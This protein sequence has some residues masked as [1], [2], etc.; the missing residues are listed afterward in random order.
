M[1]AD[2]KLEILPGENASCIT[3][4][5]LNEDHTLGNALRY[6]LMKNP[7]VEFAG[8]SVPHPNEPKMNLR[9]QTRPGT[10]AIQILRKALLDLANVANA[11]MSEFTAKSV[12]LQT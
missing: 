3:C 6:V 4:V 8:Y 7:E 1:E 9:L 5:F 10:E 12:V 2:K 11:V